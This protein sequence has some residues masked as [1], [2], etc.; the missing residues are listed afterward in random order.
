[1]EDSPRYE[2]SLAALQM[3]FEMDTSL[4]EEDSEAR[5]AEFSSKVDV[6]IS[7]MMLEDI[8]VLY[9]IRGQFLN[10]L[11]KHKQKSFFL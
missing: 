7:Q 11:N 10:L 2:S 3:K 9:T 4:K 5:V 1:M 8:I 6:E